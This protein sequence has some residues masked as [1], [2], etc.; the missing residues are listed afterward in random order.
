[1][2]STHDENTNFLREREQADYE[3][4]VRIK[5]AESHA[6]TRPNITTD[7]LRQQLQCLYQAHHDAA[8]V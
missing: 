8:S 5:V 6:D 3:E 2:N 4:R 7:Q 1:M